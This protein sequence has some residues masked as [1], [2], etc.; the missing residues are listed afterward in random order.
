MTTIENKRE[1]VAS[2]RDI[3]R[4]TAKVTQAPK[5]Q[6][7]QGGEVG[8]RISFDSQPLVEGEGKKAPIDGQGT[9]SGTALTRKQRDGGAR[10]R[11]PSRYPTSRSAGATVT[12]SAIS[13]GSRP[14][15]EKFGLLYP[16]VV[17]SDSKLIAGECCL[18]AFKLLGREPNPRHDDRPRQAAARRIRREHRTQGFHG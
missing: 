14:S 18:A 9:I 7:F 13:R 1:Y 5:H 15:I 10:G 11:L 17:T 8:E 3:E 6:Q 16:V 4:A 12:I 2:R